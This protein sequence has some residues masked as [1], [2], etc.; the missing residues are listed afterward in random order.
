MNTLTADF[1]LKIAPHSFHLCLSFLHASSLWIEA[2]SQGINKSSMKKRINFSRRI[3]LELSTR[4]GCSFSPYEEYGV[5]Q[6]TFI[7]IHTYIRTYGA[8]VC[9]R[10]C[11]YNNYRM[12]AFRECCRPG[13]ICRSSQLR[14]EQFQL[15]LEAALLTSVVYMYVCILGINLTACQSVYIIYTDDGFEGLI[16]AARLL[17]GYIAI[18]SYTVI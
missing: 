13:S 15:R 6:C 16:T 4:F 10:A 17:P 5:C 8:C 11:V 9:V 14:Q 12:S 7:R 18:L 3:E 2:T 1:N